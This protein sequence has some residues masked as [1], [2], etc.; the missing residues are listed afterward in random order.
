MIKRIYEFD[1]RFSPDGYYRGKVN[2]AAAAYGFSYDFCRFYS[3]GGGYILI[4]NSSCVMTGNFKKGELS[5]FL[6]FCGAYSLECPG[7]D[8][9]A[10]FKP[11]KRTRLSCPVS[12]Y[13]YDEK[14]LRVDSGFEDIYN[15]LLS[16]FGEKIDHDLWYADISHRVRHGVSSTFLYKNC[17]AGRIDFIGGSCGYFSDI[18]VSPDHRRKGIGEELLKIM[19]A[20]LFRKG[21]CGE[22][23]AYNDVLPFYL[24]RGF[25]TL[26][27]DVYYRRKEI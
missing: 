24:R 22:L 5:E 21:L 18:A 4:Y 9:P 20:Y 8:A 13:E 19:G 17:A 7:G 26:G 16:S 2:A 6:D 10:G 1:E 25:K 3:Y 15:I 11:Y 27:S 14:L 23:Y 12:E